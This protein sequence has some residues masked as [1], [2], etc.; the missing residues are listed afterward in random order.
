MF[1]I[2]QRRR[3]DKYS[4]A[5]RKLEQTTDIFLENTMD[6]EMTMQGNESCLT[7]GDKFVGTTAKFNDEWE[8]VSLRPDLRPKEYAPDC[9]G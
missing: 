9:Y 2:W 6:D 5:R 4:K 3:R 7:E 8:I 1:R